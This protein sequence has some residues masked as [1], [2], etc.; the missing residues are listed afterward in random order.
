M[1]TLAPIGE[2]EE[3]IVETLAT[4]VAEHFGQR[5]ELAGKAR[6]PEAGWSQDRQQYLAA[7]L[8]MLVPSPEAGN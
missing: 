7:S 5:V 1:I 3:A 6:L 4:R 2:V 8:L